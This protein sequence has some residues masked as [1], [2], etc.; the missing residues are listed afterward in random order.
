MKNLFFLSILILTFKSTLAQLFLNANLMQK[1][2]QENEIRL[3]VLGNGAYY[4]QGSGHKYAGSGGIIA[5][6]P[7]KNNGS[8]SLCLK[9][10]P[11]YQKT[12]RFRDTAFNIQSYLPDV[13]KQIFAFDNGSNYNVGMRYNKFSSSTSKTKS[14][15]SIIGDF[16]ATPYDTKIDST[17]WNT[18]DTTFTRNY[19]L[20]NGFMLLNPTLGFT[21]EWLFSANKNSD[22]NIKISIGLYLT[23]TF[24]YEKEAGKNVIPSYNYMLLGKNALNTNLSLNKKLKSFYSGMVSG[25]LE[26]NDF[27]FYL[28][29][30]YN[31]VL[32]SASELEIKG[33][34]NRPLFINMGVG[35]SPSLIHFNF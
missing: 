17:Y 34:N 24:V 9:Y 21:R 14:I 4:F 15:W 2:I 29:F 12:F 27:R 19:T 25:M 7:N 10:N 23:A 11:V 30:Q 6:I 31:Y 16:N 18:L 8:L 20:S 33:I 35:F 26:F 5:F 32:F 13:A 22:Q 28:N 3:D 1:A